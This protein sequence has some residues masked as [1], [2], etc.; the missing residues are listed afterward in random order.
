MIHHQ[1]I[2]QKHVKG[3]QDFQREPFRSQVINGAQE[4]E[5]RRREAI[6]FGDSFHCFGQ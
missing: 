1:N 6:G 5:D 2:E 3:L 4:K